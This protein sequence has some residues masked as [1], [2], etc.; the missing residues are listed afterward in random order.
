[1]IMRSRDGKMGHRCKGKEVLWLSIFISLMSRNS[2][3]LKWIWKNSYAREEKNSFLLD[4]IR[5]SIEITA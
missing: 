2:E 5:G 3:Q 1:M 4:G